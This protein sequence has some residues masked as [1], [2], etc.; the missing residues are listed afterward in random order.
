MNT[1]LYIKLEFLPTGRFKTN[2]SRKNL[3]VPVFF[4]KFKD[5]TPEAMRRCRIPYKGSLNYV[6]NFDVHNLDFKMSMIQI[7]RCS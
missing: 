7:S 1:A 3:L 5:D 4:F 6:H 2:I